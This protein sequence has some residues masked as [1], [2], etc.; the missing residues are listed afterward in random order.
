MTIIVCAL[1]CTDNE[2]RL[3]RRVRKG[4]RGVIADNLEELCGFVLDLASC[5]GVECGRVGGAKG[6]D[7]KG[8]LPIVGG[9]ES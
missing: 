6:K 7:R 5:K 3:S 4:D 2:G 1:E 9:K 8:P